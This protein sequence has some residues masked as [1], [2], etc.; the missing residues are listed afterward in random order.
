MNAH[1]PLLQPERS[2]P[3]DGPASCQDTRAARSAG[4]G[5]DVALYGI[6][7][8]SKLLTEPGRLETTLARVMEVLASF[9]EMRHGLIALLGED[10]APEMVVGSEWSEATAKRYFE[11][12]PERAIGQIVVTEMPFV[13]ED[14][15]HEPLF[16]GWSFSDEDPPSAEVAFIGV[17]IKDRGRVDRHADH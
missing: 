5:P 15:R 17:P 9:L 2:E 3:E 12:L 7:E 13:V 8:I 6:Y 11:R 14:V 16:D 4:C 1:L 10:G